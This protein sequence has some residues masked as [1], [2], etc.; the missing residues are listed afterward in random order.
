[1]VERV[2]LVAAAAVG[3]VR[4][5]LSLV[6][7]GSAEQ[8]DVH[9]VAIAVA[10]HL[11]ARVLGGDVAIAVVGAQVH[12][13]GGHEL[14]R[15]QRQGHHTGGVGLFVVDDLLVRFLVGAGELDEAAG[16][17]R[18]VGQE[19]Q[20][21]I[22]DLHPVVALLLVQAVVVDSEGASRRGVLL[23][24]A[25]ALSVHL[26][27]AVGFLA[28]HPLLRGEG[29]G[30]AVVVAQVVQHAVLHLH[31][32]GEEAVERQVVVGLAPGQRVAE[33][34]LV[35]EGGVVPAPVVGVVGVVAAA[36]AGIARVDAS[37]YSMSVERRGEVYIA[38]E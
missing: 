11:H 32:R 27:G 15:V 14:V 31:A 24:D 30:G 3:H 20:A 1:M 6:N 33:H 17:A 13:I 18:S 16:A 2:G 8:T 5:L 25:E 7:V 9:Y 28:R 26:V 29:N 22:G 10:I 23:E 37:I 38:A 4:V 19:I 35:G 34:H 21:V 12:R 36:V